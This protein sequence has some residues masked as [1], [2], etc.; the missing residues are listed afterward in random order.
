MRL[1]ARRAEEKLRKEEHLLNMQIMRERVRAAPLLLEGPTY[2]GP[3]VGQKSHLC[4][5]DKFLKKRPMTRSRSLSN[6]RTMTITP[7]TESDLE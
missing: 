4:K 7:S 3:H 5:R 6:N 2:W 1:A